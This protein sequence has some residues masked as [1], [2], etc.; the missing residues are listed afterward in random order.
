MKIPY[1][2]RAVPTRRLLSS[3]VGCAISYEILMRDGISR[4]ATLK[5]P[6]ELSRN[7]NLLKWSSR[8]NSTS[9]YCTNRTHPTWTNC[10]NLTV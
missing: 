10:I 7:R 5:P 3:A 2:K 8:H 6:T 4:Q 9:Q 1:P